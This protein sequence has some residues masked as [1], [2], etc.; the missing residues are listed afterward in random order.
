MCHI[1]QSRTKRRLNYS[2]G[3]WRTTYTRRSQDLCCSVGIALAQRIREHALLEPFHAPGEDHTK[4]VRFTRHRC[5]V[6]NM[7]KSPA[8]EHVISRRINVYAL[9]SCTSRTCVALSV[10][11]SATCVFGVWREGVLW[12]E[13]YICIKVTIFIIQTVNVNAGYGK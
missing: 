3:M 2:R 11:N 6:A 1:F 5:G 12:R 7:C 8:S 9:P 4:L 13:V 10:Y